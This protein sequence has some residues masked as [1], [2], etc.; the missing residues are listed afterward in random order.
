MDSHVGQLFTTRL[1][2]NAYQSNIPKLQ[3]WSTM[4]TTVCEDFLNMGMLPLEKCTKH[5]RSGPLLTVEMSKKCTPLRREAHV[6]VKMYNTHHVRITFGSWDVEKVHAVVARSTFRSQNVQNTRGSDHFWRFRMFKK[7]MPLWR[8]ARFEVKMFKTLGV[9]TTFGGS[10]VASL[11]YTT[12]HYTTLHYT[13][14]QDI[15]LQYTTLHYTTLQ[16]TPLH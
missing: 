6:E 9:R 5:T 15:T 3:V 4:T 2:W 16:Y 13:T 12:L 10:D 7:C 8:E 11:H 1:S 14:L